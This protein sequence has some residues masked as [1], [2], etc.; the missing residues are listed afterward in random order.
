MAACTISTSVMARWLTASVRLHEDSRE[1]MMEGVGHR[2]E[3][4]RENA[5][6]PS[7]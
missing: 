4:M 6:L 7:S 5:S 1:Q 3:P 2:E